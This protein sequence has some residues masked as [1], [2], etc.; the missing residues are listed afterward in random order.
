[1][2]DKPSQLDLIGIKV[3]LFDWA[4]ELIANTLDPRF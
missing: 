3:V 1:M 4:A 2:H